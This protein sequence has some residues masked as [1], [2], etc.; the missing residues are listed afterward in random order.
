MA[1]GNPFEE[2]RAAALAGVDWRR[3]PYKMTDKRYTRWTCGYQA[4]LGEK[5]KAEKA[6][7]A[8]AQQAQPAQEVQG[9]LLCA[10]R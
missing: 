3:G 6:E 9:A 2:G 5:A 1:N 7:K 10:G 4:G 8:Q